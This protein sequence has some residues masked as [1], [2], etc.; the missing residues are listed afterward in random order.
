MNI[1]KVPSDLKKQYC[2]GTWWNSVKWISL[3]FLNNFDLP[4]DLNKNSEDRVLSELCLTMVSKYVSY[5]FRNENSPGN[6][7]VFPRNVS[8]LCEQRNLEQ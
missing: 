4:L 7:P 8:T 1:V 5:H 6:F 2:G 3:R